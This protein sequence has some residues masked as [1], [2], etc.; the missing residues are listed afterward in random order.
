MA[1]SLFY[2]KRRK[3]MPDQSKI[4]EKAQKR[5]ATEHKLSPAFIKTNFDRLLLDMERYGYEYYLEE[6]KKVNV[7][8][9]KE[10]LSERFRRLKDKGVAGLQELI[11]NNF[12]ALDDFFKS[13]GQSRKSRAGQSF[14]ENLKWLFKK[15]GYPF[16]EKILINGRPDFLI[17]GVK[18]YK[19]NPMNCIIF[20]A[21]RTLRERWRQ[22]VTEGTRGLGFFLATLDD[23]K[24]TDEISEMMKHRIYMVVP[25]PIKRTVVNYKNA[26][27]VISFTE[28]FRNHLDPALQRLANTGRG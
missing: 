1:N 5:I 7:I 2:D 13:L 16:D 20:T 27:N 10:Y 23:D 21:K 22:I 6:Q 8:L 28:F 14:E 4:I 3:L 15:L 26:P 18:E 24:S 17:P 19:R 12:D 9:L 11:E 25:E